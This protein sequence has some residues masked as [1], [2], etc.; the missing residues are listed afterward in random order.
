M[1]FVLS[2][3][4]SVVLLQSQV[5][6]LS[7]G[8]QYTSGVSVVGTY[9]GV[10]IPDGNATVGSANA[11]ALF[12]LGVPETGLATGTFV[13]FAFGRVF[14]GTI[15]GFANPEDQD[16][17]G[18]LESSFEFTTTQ[19]VTNTTVL[20]PGPPPVVTTEQVVL[21]EDIMV[22]ANGSLATDIKPF[23]TEV[24]GTA[25]R[26]EGTAAL[27][28]VSNNVLVFPLVSLSFVVSGIRQ[29]ASAPETGGG[30]GGFGVLLGGFF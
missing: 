8:P 19:I 17:Q 4:L 9:S 25:V 12:T 2:F 7:G 24:G 14:T 18:I 28:F 15:T 22:S 11:I 6:A 20:D 23:T 3:L 30:G 27:D 26:L 13:C 16:I 1:R 21:T 10:L 29:S 5:F